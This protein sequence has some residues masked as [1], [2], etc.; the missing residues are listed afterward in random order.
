MVEYVELKLE[1]REWTSKKK[2]TTGQTYCF[3][4]QSQRKIEFC[5][6]NIS[7]SVLDDDIKEEKIPPVFGWIND[8][9]ERQ[10]QAFIEEYGDTVYYHLSTKEMFTK[11]DYDT[12]MN[13]VEEIEQVSEQVSDF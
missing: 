8:M 11:S 4:N 10:Y 6:L 2:G 9:N 13:D 1:L 7:L 12:L 5:G 3:N